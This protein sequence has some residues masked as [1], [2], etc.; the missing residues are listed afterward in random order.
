MT[1]KQHLFDDFSEEKKILVT[2]ALSVF[3][4][5]FDP[6]R[7]LVGF[8]CVDHLWWDN[9]PTLNY[10]LA[11][12]LTGRTE[13]P[14]AAAL[15]RGIIED[16]LARQLVAP[17]EI[18]HGVFRHPLEQEP[19]SGILDPGRLGLYGEHLMDLTLER[20][21]DS[22]HEILSHDPLLK[23]LPAGPLGAALHRAVL[24]AYPVVWDTYEP[25]SREF[26]TLTFLMMLHH[27][28]RELAALSPDL[29]QRMRAAIGHA[30]EGAIYR[31]KS[32]FT[33]LNT[34]VLCMHIFEL[35]YL[36]RHWHRPEWQA[37]GLELAERLLHDYREHHAVA[38]FNSPTYCA[39]DLYVLPF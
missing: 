10:A 18:F 6:A 16:V 5:S 21:E 38:E 11:L 39:V 30:M 13:H 29:P 33:P 28:E 36:G 15:A 34:N 14:E 4:A 8:P 35:E 2:D 32:N 23:D 17:G 31:S 27:M 24:Q 19:P 9:R 20:I 7:R 25:N 26:I 37:Y 22:F 1:E 12:L 3:E